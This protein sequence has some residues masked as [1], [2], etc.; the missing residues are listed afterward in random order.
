MPRIIYQAWWQRDSWSGPSAD[1]YTLHKDLDARSRY[2]TKYWEGMPDE[3]PE[4]Y[5]CPEGAPVW[6]D[7]PDHLYEMISKPLN[8]K[9]GLRF[10]SNLGSKEVVK[11]LENSYRLEILDMVKAIEDEKAHITKVSNY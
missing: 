10:Y 2:N 6:L 3:T 1:G 7:L 8:S 11:M 4:T 9:D 5:E